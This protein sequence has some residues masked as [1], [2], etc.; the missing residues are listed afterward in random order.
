M[1]DLPQ[2]VSLG[3]ALTDFV[4][5][6]EADWRSAAG[7]SC[8]NVARSAAA[9]GVPSAW[10]G[11]VSTDRFGDEIAALSESGGL[12][13]RFI[14]RAHREP[15]IAMVHD[16]EPPAYQF[17]GAD[18]ADLAFDPDELPAGWL[19]AVQLAH[20]GCISLVRPGLGERL[21]E[22]ADA[23]HQRGTAICFDPNM[24]RL[25]G[26][27]YPALFERLAALS[28][29]IKLS[30][31]DLAAIYPQIETEA[32]LAHV[33]AIAPRAIVVYTRGRAGMVGYRG[34]ESARQPA[35]SVDAAAGDS[36]GAGD[37]CI[38]GLVA[39]YFDRPDA[40]VAEHLRMAA[41]TAAAACCRTGAHA[42]TRH[43]VDAVLA[44]G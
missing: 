13:T 41:A 6:G 27:D 38:G 37:A 36:V 39:G 33:R 24:R 12:D 17:L 11:A 40:P 8:W 19:D 28:T 32:A 25:M 20:F 16:T 18:A 21:I 9:L 4:R 43:E 35:F 3:E 15:L 31:E 44:A 1:S 22:L 10:A 2:F 29:L 34:D 30:D 23:L 42:P 7:G 14:Q 5:I 26:P